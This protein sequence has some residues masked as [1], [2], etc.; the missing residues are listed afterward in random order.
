[1]SKGLIINGSAT[2][3]VTLTLKDLIEDVAGASL[4]TAWTSGDSISISNFAASMDTGANTYSVSFDADASLE[5]PGLAGVEMNNVTF[6]MQASKPKGATEE[7]YD[8]SFSG[9]LELSHGSDTFL[10]SVSGNYDSGD[11]TWTVSAA[12]QQPIYL[13]AVVNTLLADVDLS[14]LDFLAGAIGAD[15]TIEQLTLS[16]S[17]DK[18]GDYTF[19]ATADFRKWSIDLLGD[20]SLEVTVPSASVSINVDST[21]T[22][23]ATAQG[24]ASIPELGLQVGASCNLSNSDGS[25]ISLTWEG[26]QGTYTRTQTGDQTLTLQADNW[27]VGKV[28]VSLA[29]TIGIENFQ[30]DSPWD[31]LNEIV[32]QELKITYDFTNKNISLTCDLSSGINLYFI[33]IYGFT[34]ERKNTAPSGQAAVYDVLMTLDAK[35]LGDL[36]S[37]TDWKDLMSS[38]SGGTG[39]GKSIKNM[40]SVPGKGNKYFDLEYLGL[41]QRVTVASESNIDTVGAAISYLEDAFKKPSGASPMG[42]SDELKFSGDSSWLIGTKLTLLDA[43]ELGFVFNDPV[44]YGLLIEVNSKSKQSGKSKAGKLLK[45]LNGLKFEILYKKVSDTIGMYYIELKLPSEMRHLQ[46]GEVAVTLPVLSLNIYTNGNFKVDV[47][48]PVSMTN[49]S[50]SLTIQAFPFTGSGGFYFADLDEATAKG[51]P[52]TTLGTFHPVIEFGFALNLGLGKSIHK[53][54]LK[55]GISV[56]ALG[57]LQGTLAWFHPTSDTKDSDIYYRLQGTFGLMGK[58]YGDINFAIVQAN[59]SLMVTA[60]ATAVLQSYKDIPLTLYAAVEAHAEIS[61]DCG[62]FTIHIGFSFSTSITEHMTVG[63]NAPV[64]EVPWLTASAGSQQIAPPEYFTAIDRN[65]MFG[66]TAIT[67]NWS[68]FAPPTGTKKNLQFYFVPQVT[69]T[70][71]TEAEYV[72][73]IYMDAPASADSYSKLPA[74]TNPPA[75]GSTSFEKLSGGVLA[76][77]VNAMNGSSGQTLSATEATAVTIAELKQYLQVLETSSHL[78]TVSQIQNFLQTQF[79]LSISAPQN[80]TSASAFFSAVFPMFP[81][82]LMNYFTQTD[83]GPVTG[84]SVT[85]DRFTSAEPDYLNDLQAFFADLAT[86]YEKNQGQA[87][88]GDGY[89]ASASTSITSFV[90]QDY[91]LMLAKSVLQHAIDYLKTYEQPKSTS[92]SESLSGIVNNYTTISASNQVDPVQL[93]QQNTGLKLA[94]SLNLALNSYTLAASESLTVADLCSKFSVEV[95][96]FL[97]ANFMVEG[98]FALGST[99]QFTSGGTSNTSAA[100]TGADS[101]RSIIQGLETAFGSGLQIA[102]GALIAQNATAILNTG[103]VITIPNLLYHT[104]SGDTLTSISKQFLTTLAGSDT[105]AYAAIS[106]TATSV[107]NATQLLQVNSQTAG[108]FLPG[109]AIAAN[110]TNYT[111]AEGDTLISILQGLGG[112]TIATLLAGTVTPAGGSA[113]AIDQVACLS[114]N[115]TLMLPA[116]QYTTATASTTTLTQLAHSYNLTVEDLALSNTGLSGLWAASQ[117]IKIPNLLALDLGTIVTGLYNNGDL[118]N[119]AGMGSR[120]FLSGLQLPETDNL[121]V[122]GPSFITQ[123]AA[124]TNTSETAPSGPVGLYQLTGQQFPIQLEETFQ[125]ELFFNGF[126][127]NVGESV[128][129]THESLL[130]RV[131][132]QVH[133]FLHHDEAEAATTDSLKVQLSSTEIAAIQKKETALST[134]SFGETSDVLDPTQQV[135]IHF[136]QGTTTP[137]KYPGLAL[138]GLTSNAQLTIVPLSEHTINYIQETAS[139]TASVFSLNRIDQEHPTYDPQVGV[140]GAVVWATKLK[141]EIKEL[142]HSPMA[143]GACYELLGVDNEDLV[144]LQRLIAVASSGTING[145]HA[146]YRPES[147]SKSPEGYESASLADQQLLITQADLAQF[148]STNSGISNTVTPP[149]AGLLMPDLNFLELLLQASEERHGGY[150]LYCNDATTGKGFPSSVFNQKSVGEITLVLTLTTAANGAVP[151]YA[152]ALLANLPSATKN[153][154]L[155]LECTNQST[156]VSTMPVGNY[157]FEVTRPNPASLSSSTKEQIYLLQTFSLLT[158]TLSGTNFNTSN[159]SMPLSPKKEHGATDSNTWY[160]EQTFPL[161]K[162]STQTYNGL[163][164]MPNGVIA[165]NNPYLGIGDTATIDMHWVDLF[166]NSLES[167]VPSSVSISML[168]RDPI[169]GLDQLPGL[170]MTYLVSGG[171]LSIHFSFATKSYGV[172]GTSAEVAAGVKQAQKDLYTYTQSFYQMQTLFSY[173]SGTVPVVLGCS[174]EGTIESTTEHAVSAPD[175]NLIYTTAINYLEEVIARTASAT[176]PAPWTSAPIAM[177]LS[178]TSAVFELMVILSIQRDVSMI[179]TAYNAVEHVQKRKIMMKADTDAAQGDKHSSLKNF[180]QLFESS[181]NTGSTAWYKLAM[182]NDQE[183]VDGTTPAKKIWVVQFGASGISLNFAAGSASYAPAPLATAIVNLNNVSVNDYGSTNAKTKNFASV[184]LDKWGRTVLEA[185]DEILL[186]EYAV[187]ASIIGNAQATVADNYYDQILTAKQ[188]IA[189]AISNGV[190]PIEAGGAAISQ[191][192]QKQ[193]KEQLLQ[194]LSTAYDIEAITEHPLTAAVSST[195]KEV[196]LHG[197]PKVGSSS[198]A[199][200]NYSLSGGNIQAKPGNTAAQQLTTFLTVKGHGADDTPLSLSGVDYVI[201]HIEHQLSEGGS[202]LSFIIPPSVTDL[203]NAGLS[204]ALNST[205]SL[206]IPLMLRSYPT[207][208]SLLGQSFTADMPADHA[209]ITSVTD[210]LK[211]DYAFTYTLVAAEQDQ[212]QVQINYNATDP[213]SGNGSTAVAAGAFETSLANFIHQYPQMHEDL[214][215]YLPKI[216]PGLTQTGDVYTK[217]QNALKAFAGQVNTIATNWKTWTELQPAST[218]VAA[219]N[220]YTVTETQG[221]NGLKMSISPAVVAPQTLLVQIPNSPYVP[222]IVSGAWTGQFVNA[223]DATQYLSYEDRNLYPQRTLVFGGLSL[224]NQQSAWAGVQII[225]N[226]R[227]LDPEG[228]GAATTNAAFIFQSPVVKQKNVLDPILEHTGSYSLRVLGMDATTSLDALFSALQAQFFGLSSTLSKVVLRFQVDYR[229]TLTSDDLGPEVIVPIVLTTQ[230]D[231]TASDTK[232]SNLATYV[233]EWVTK[234]GMQQNTAAGQSNGFYHYNG[235]LNIKV[236]Q[237]SNQNSDTPVAVLDGLYI[238]IE[239]ISDWTS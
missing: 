135:P 182:G 44:L 73:M 203:T 2:G 14:S 137:W 87:G 122:Y 219:T 183:T 100:T 107:D 143:K 25:S 96:D 154:S 11:D 197:K 106:G 38:S 21:G 12:T 174:L 159:P 34:L 82:F 9:T 54:I 17:K 119:T 173:N 84:R 138:A 163:A 104:Q 69:F 43:I 92:V 45:V 191:E 23:T 4:P 57:S 80:A 231:Y 49:F 75:P 132:H 110:S 125:V 161:Y 156:P 72:A 48:Y 208:P 155:Y 29:K 56:V 234:R 94:D 68:A 112:C 213:T 115:C 153:T 179:D 121:T 76:W 223:H 149:G 152:N 50:N 134:L 53:G 55:A 16:R 10:M 220:V 93:A 175:I 70:S 77:V 37:L 214:V 97:E 162:F 178:N 209:S 108:L 229:Y 5:I 3:T 66:S 186:P 1:M 188:N 151:N 127:I 89:S 144:L 131:E 170:S 141:V 222:E 99:F 205:G 78:F 18:S 26:I 233:R 158:Y 52:V 90:F 133:D 171:N 74:G 164:T 117:S 202:M 199:K 63:S 230:Y 130:S 235:R 128:S 180:A 61:I 165:G 237:Y 64:S 225:R 160:Y 71:A 185:I 40:P 120:I 126:S 184:N 198:T 116:I 211:W 193:F 41:G 113:T 6:S 217:A 86:T 42:G 46:F 22:K 27:S 51:L 228:T 169:I 221:T 181:Y 123:G 207:P 200:S 218:E 105:A 20:S 239:D 224:L 60:R 83:G 167:P 192:G 212:V 227:L 91:F 39:N 216:Y 148:G 124:E 236:T 35:A 189:K 166:G 136:A 176:G 62:F 33:D 30:L 194:K 111:V 32:I 114:T 195:D 150:Y 210:L 85:F 206:D 102:P 187:P 67:P 28:I 142:P 177:T 103:A 145:I 24:D 81:D 226:S 15:V 19:K 215:T 118:I 58:V 146:L 79:A 172:G 65:S 59:V 201:Q 157:G 36:A 168:Y 8:L 13:A 139:L 129:S 101:L 232:L 7:E 47:G 196:I 95:A 31:L 190:Q 109:T 238:L 147:Q 140:I 88:S 98:L 204:L